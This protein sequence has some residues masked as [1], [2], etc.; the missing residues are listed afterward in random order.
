QG[1]CGGAR[2]HT[3]R[4]PAQLMGEVRPAAAT[5]WSELLPHCLPHDVERRTPV[6]V[7][8][9]CVVDERL[10]VPS[11][12]LVHESPEV[13]QYRVIQPNRSLC[14]ARFRLY[15]GTTLRAREV[16]VAVLLS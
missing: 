2:R 10:V 12:G 11:T 1:A 15:D 3:P 14:L 8:K 9:Q 4:T 6:D 7:L 13:L 5:V 16:D